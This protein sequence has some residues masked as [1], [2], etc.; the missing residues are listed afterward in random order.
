VGIIKLLVGLV[1][2]AVV[3]DVLSHVFS[4]SSLSFSLGNRVRV[5][6]VTST[7]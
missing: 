5:V 6:S 3:A 1:V 4:F 2:V 7:R